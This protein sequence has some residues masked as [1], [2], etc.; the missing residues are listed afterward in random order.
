MPTPLVTAAVNAAGKTIYRQAG[1]FISKN[2]FLRE[3]RR[4]PAGIKGAG[5]FVSRAAF[6]R[7]LEKSGIAQR[8]M[9]EIGAP[10]GGGD[11]VSRVRKSSDK[12][13]DMLAD[14][15]QLG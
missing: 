5:Q 4:I 8:L 10:I 7:G 13:T 2:K 15:N 11:W 12:F 6:A 3:S 1:R 14:N 9:D